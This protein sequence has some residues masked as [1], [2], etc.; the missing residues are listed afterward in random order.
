MSHCFPCSGSGWYVTSSYISGSVEV[1][2]LNGPFSCSE[3]AEVF[4]NAL[5]PT[6]SNPG[7][8]SYVLI[9]MFEHHTERIEDAWWFYDRLANDGW[10]DENVEILTE[11]IG[12][13]SGSA[14]VPV[15]SG[16]YELRL[17]IKNEMDVLPAEEVKALHAQFVNNIIESLDIMQSVFGPRT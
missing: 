3:D 8:R 17:R 15:L 1:P 4:A 13:A 16:A 12:E 2:H 11:L 10:S 9:D 6:S 5:I 14:I 7:E